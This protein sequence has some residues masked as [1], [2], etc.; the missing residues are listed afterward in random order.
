MSYY[1]DTFN[2]DLSAVGKFI[3]CISSYVNAAQWE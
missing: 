3:T 1:S 2:E